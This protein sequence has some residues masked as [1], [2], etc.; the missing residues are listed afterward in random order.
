MQYK[1]SVKNWKTPVTDYRQ[2]DNARVLN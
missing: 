2:G 1:Q